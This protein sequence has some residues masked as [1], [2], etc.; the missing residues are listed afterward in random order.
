MTDTVRYGYSL[1]IEPYCEN[2]LEFEPECHEVDVS[3]FDGCNI[4]HDI[5]C[6]H[7][8]K[9]RRMNKHIAAMRN[10]ANVQ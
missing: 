5:F 4:M 2:C 10:K 9:C 7:Q 6:V 1:S 8:D 3:S